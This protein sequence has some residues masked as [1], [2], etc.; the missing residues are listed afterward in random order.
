MSFT[1]KPME[2]PEVIIIEP[3]VHTDDRGFFAETYKKTEF[4]KNGISHEFVQGNHSYSEKGVIR[5]LH[6]QTWPHAQGKLVSVLSGKILDVAVDLR[7]DSKTFGKWVSAELSE[8]NHRMLWIPAGFAHGFLA[9]ETSH[10][11]YK[12]TSEYDQKTEGGITWN[13]RDIGI[14]WPESSPRLSER[15]LKLRGFR[16]QAHLFRWSD[17]Q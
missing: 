1:F 6:F 10:V 15:D 16:E 2:I 7:P 5:G 3:S 13:D 8:K 11:I 14:E 9:I 12:V 17:G 4:I